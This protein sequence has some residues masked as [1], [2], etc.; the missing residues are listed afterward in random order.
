MLNRNDGVPRRVDV[1][2]AT[3]AETAIREAMRLVERMG[4]NPTLTDAVAHLNYA[5]DH[6]ADFVDDRLTAP[7]L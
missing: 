4:A 2:L 6:V 3:P 1:T 7:P 5:L